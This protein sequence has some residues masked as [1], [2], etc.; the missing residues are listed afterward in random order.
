MV[1]GNKETGTTEYTIK[2]LCASTI[3]TAKTQ[4]ANINIL[5]SLHYLKIKKTVYTKD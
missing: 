3:F 5:L 4:S 1:Y 2:V